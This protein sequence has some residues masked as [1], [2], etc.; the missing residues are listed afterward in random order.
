MKKITGFLKNRTVLGI[1]CIGVA[2]VI[3]FVVLPLTVNSSGS[4]LRV[5]RAV[6]DIGKGRIITA[7]DV[8]LVEVGKTGLPQNCVTDISRVVGKYAATD[9]KKEDYIFESKLSTEAMSADSLFRRL[10]GDK[11]A[12]SVTIESLA[13]GLS[14]KLESGDIVRLII[15]KDKA[16]FTP[17]ELS[18]VKVITSTTK[19]GVDKE[20]LASDSSSYDKIPSTVTLLVNDIQASLLVDFENSAKIHIC[21]VY[22]G[23][24]EYAESFIEEQD[25]Y[26][27]NREET[28]TVKY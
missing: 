13:A 5:V 14:G 28:D 21:L 1:L 4:K 17:E 27:L 12:V 3:A 19:N 24:E 8:T 20:N 6:N 23:S 15:Y 18:Y 11:Y 7:D 26:F 25:R 22:R 2:A 9:I 16:S 10:N